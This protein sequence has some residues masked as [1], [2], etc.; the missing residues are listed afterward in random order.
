M[1]LAYLKFIGRKLRPVELAMF[2]KWAL[3][4]RRKPFAYRDVFQFYIDPISDFGLQLQ[5]F[6]KYEP[7][8]T[9]EIS[10][11]LTEGDTF[12]DLGAN[13][14]FFS[15]IASRLVGKRGHVVCIE[16]QQ[17]LWEVITKNFELNNAF[18]CQLL[19]YAAAETSGTATIFLYTT[20]NTGASSLSKGFNFKISFPAI[21][22]FFYGT[23]TIKTTTL[24]EVVEQIG[25]TK[26]KLIK[27]DIEGFEFE[28]LKGSRKA[29]TQKVFD[30]LLVEIHPEALVKMGQSPEQLSQYLAG[31]GYTGKAITPNLVLYTLS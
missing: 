11:M 15:V 23:S 2:A 26:I 7:A 29:L 19:P 27:V 3:R 1:Q 31:F 12:V 20:L 16:P 30:N 25:L 24:D 21:R 13:E 14:G 6:G 9:D 18:N 28:A 5:E 8:M 17:R 10:R 4:T 22:K